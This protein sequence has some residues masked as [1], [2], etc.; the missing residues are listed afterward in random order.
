[1]IDS[2][3]LLRRAG[4]TPK[5]SF[6]QNFLIDDGVAHDI[7]RACV[8][9]AEM[10][11]SFVVELGAGA[12]ALTSLLA[13]RAR[14]LTAVERDRDLVP[15]LA[16]TFASEIG[17]G[18]LSVLEA[19]AQSIDPTFLLAERPSGSLGVLCGNLP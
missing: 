7:A 4:L 5:K 18:K 3:G 6:G 1:M 15:L 14:R 17:E 12:G 19:D 10:G 8:A 9:D 11:K 16:S 13:P 2:R